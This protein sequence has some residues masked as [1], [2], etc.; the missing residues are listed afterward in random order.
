MN[1]KIS[2]ILNKVRKCFTNSFVSIDIMYFQFSN[3]NT[4]KVTYKL[5]IENHSFRTTHNAVSNECNSIEGLISHINHE[6][7]F[8]SG[9]TPIKQTP[10]GKRE[11]NLLNSK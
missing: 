10:K 5:Y 3:G 2:E 9:W 7:E 6:L 4:I 1:N 8:V 11:L